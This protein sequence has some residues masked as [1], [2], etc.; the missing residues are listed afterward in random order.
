MKIFTVKKRAL[1]FV[2]FHFSGKY[3]SRI[4]IAKHILSSANNLEIRQTVFFRYKY[5]YWKRYLRLPLP[6][7]IT[8]IS[9]GDQ[10]M[11]AVGNEGYDPPPIFKGSITNWNICHGALACG[12]DR[13]QVI[14]DWANK[15]RR[16]MPT[17]PKT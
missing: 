15:K 8:V 11:L 9:H 17:S 12:R 14:S 7:W 13:C 1:V 6:H 10:G 5:R 4:C 3:F 2:G 16:N